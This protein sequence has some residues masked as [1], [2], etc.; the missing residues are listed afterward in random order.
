MRCYLAGF[1]VH[2]CCFYPDRGNDNWLV[3]YEMPDIDETHGDV[4]SLIF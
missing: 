1:Y 3:K 4:S 2:V